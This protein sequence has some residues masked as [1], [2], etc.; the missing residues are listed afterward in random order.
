MFLN[1]LFRR[2]KRRNTRKS[3]IINAKYTTPKNP[4]YTY[5]TPIPEPGKSRRKH[6]GLRIVLAV[7]GIFVLLNACSL[8]SS[9]D[10]N[11][12]KENH[13]ASKASAAL[14]VTESAIPETTRA[15]SQ[16]KPETTPE[17]VSTPKST[18]EPTPVATPEVTPEP[19]VDPASEQPPVRAV[20]EPAEDN[21]CVWVED[22]T[23]KEGGYCSNH[24][25]W[26]GVTSFAAATTAS[27]AV[28]NSSGTG[29]SN[30]QTYNEEYTGP[31]PYIGNSNSRKFHHSW[32]GSV[33]K[34]SPGNKVEFYSRDDAVNSG[35][36]PCK[37]CN[38]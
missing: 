11:S 38:P 32:C 35:Y 28:H 34:M 13:T 19:T 16:P 7:I 36:Q 20:E 8:G 37:R 2:K 30:F 5:I 27:A 22:S 12:N 6:K 4:Q 29:N 25:E 17:P 9:T 3:K 33:A 10:N 23:W 21:S 18:P 1:T 15:T 24:P 31:A 26:Y 14:P